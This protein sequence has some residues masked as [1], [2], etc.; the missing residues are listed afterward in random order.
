LLFHGDLAESLRAQ[1]QEARLLH[2][3]TQWEI[4]SLLADE[5]DSV[6]SGNCLL[7]TVLQDRWQEALIRVVADSG[8][9]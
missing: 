5:G 8:D 1:V 6:G 7:E 9:D 3:R 2:P 4:T